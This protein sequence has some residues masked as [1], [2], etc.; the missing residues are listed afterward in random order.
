MPCLRSTRSSVRITPGAPF[1]L[2]ATA[3]E[4][5]PSQRLAN[6]EYAAPEQR[7]Q[8]KQVENTADIY[9]WD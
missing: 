6:F 1:D 7:A 9:A 4:T 8:G 2:L 3:V 5:G